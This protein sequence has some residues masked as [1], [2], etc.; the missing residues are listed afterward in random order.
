MLLA[1]RKLS[2]FGSRGPFLEVPEKFLHPESHSKIL[3]FMITELCYCAAVRQEEEYY[4]LHDRR[5]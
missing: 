2:R 3:K 5:S 1:M 4:Q